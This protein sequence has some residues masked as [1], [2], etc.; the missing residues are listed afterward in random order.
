MVHN[1]VR[2]RA[3][4]LLVL[5][6]AVVSC[7]SEPPAT[8]VASPS[9]TPA[10]TAESPVS[11]EV[12]RIIS[13]MRVE[14]PAGRAVDV[15]LAEPEVPT[16]PAPV[17]TPSIPTEITVLSLM[18]VQSGSGAFQAL[19]PLPEPAAPVATVSAPIAATPPPAAVPASVLPE[20]AAAAK[21]AATATAAKPATPAPVAAATKPAV[22]AATPKPAADPEPAAPATPVVP[23]TPLPAT[24]LPAT[25]PSSARSVD[26]VQAVAETRIETV[27]GQR[28]EL[29]FPGTG[30][31][32]LGD[33]EGKEGLRYETR[34]FED[35]QAVFAMN[36]EDAGE[37]L[38]RFQ[39]QNPVDRSTEVSLVRVA[40]L[41]K[42][43]A[44]QASIPATASASATPV[45]PPAGAV[46]AS[47]A[48]A[49]ATTPAPVTPVPA[50]AAGMAATG[51]AIVAGTAALD[52]PE[53]IITLARAELDA[54]RVQSAIDALDRYLA[55]YPYGSDE[56][57]FL[58]G[59]AYEQDTPF[60]NIRKS[61]EAYKRVRDEYPRSARWSAAAERVSYLERHFFG[62]R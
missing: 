49:A 29:R 27:R 35:T 24:P 17:A 51:Q 32:Y 60:R 7:V 8:P 12:P 3:A 26:P 16:R 61:W 62:L 10:A 52:D 47:T 4:S 39:R 46:P 2:I 50:A 57:F 28:F 23:A 38:L 25:P 33:E 20:P 9:A 48:T 18:P 11:R 30:W 34:R 5:A 45:P 42:A 1:A 21:P 53:A 40:V 58:Y 41:E 14:A 54:K 37:Y 36:P 6:L 44:A 19:V 22:P 13:S 59:L 43:A 31:I 55:L 15:S 56:L